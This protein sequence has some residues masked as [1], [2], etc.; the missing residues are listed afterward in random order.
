[1]TLKNKVCCHFTS[2]SELRCTSLMQ[3]V[4]L[5]LHCITLYHEEERNKTQLKFSE[6]LVE[7]DKH[8][9]SSFF[10]CYWSAFKQFSHVSTVGVW[11]ELNTGIDIFS[12]LV[13][14]NANFVFR[15]INEVCTVYLMNMFTK[16]VVNKSH[17]EKSCHSNTYGERACFCW[18]QEAEIIPTSFPSYLAQIKIKTVVASQQS[19]KS[20]MR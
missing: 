18:P 13:W 8:N 3:E 1:M 7:M 14:L 17:S 9:C 15:T 12:Q 6:C 20:F 11:K 4:A 2:L 5:S 10:R 19:A 16:D